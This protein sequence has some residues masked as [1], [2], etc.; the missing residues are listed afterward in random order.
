[1]IALL[2]E[3]LAPFRLCPALQVRYVGQ[4]LRSFPA[5]VNPKVNRDWR[6][7]EDPTGTDPGAVTRLKRDGGAAVEVRV[8]GVVPASSEAAERTAQAVR[9]A[10]TAVQTQ[11][12]TS[13]RA[14][15]GGPVVE[16]Q[17]TVAGS[18]TR[19]AEGA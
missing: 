7:V 4:A 6:Y 8:R 3:R 17:P 16:G 2:D 18:S 15:E 14:D 11:G 19:V 13:E 5:R 10:V 1:V 9:R 12:A